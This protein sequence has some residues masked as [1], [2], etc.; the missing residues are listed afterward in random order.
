MS[1]TRLCRYECGTELGDF[2]EQENK[3]RE[4]S[5]TLHTRERCQ[6][7]KSQTI[8]GTK[9]VETNNNKHWQ[10]T[11]EAKAWVREIMEG[12]KLKELDNRL[13]LVEKILF[14]GGGIG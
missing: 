1:K 11:P 5:G 3:Y 12:P 7:I 2:D 10:P 14:Q 6:S 9:K 4:V 13:R 8:T